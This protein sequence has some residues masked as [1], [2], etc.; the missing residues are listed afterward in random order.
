M[1]IFCVGESLWVGGSLSEHHVLG[2]YDNIR[3]QK[4]MESILEQLRHN[5]NADFFTVTYL[6]IV[7]VILICS[8]TNPQLLK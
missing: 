8:E 4:P 1:Y 5:E 7:Q 6:S 3:E 2:K